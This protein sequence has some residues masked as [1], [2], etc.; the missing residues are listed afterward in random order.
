MP[1]FSKWT[2]VFFVWLIL[3]GQSRMDSGDGSGEWDDSDIA[4]EKLKKQKLVRTVLS[5]ITKNASDILY[6]ARDD[7]EV[8]ANF[9]REMKKKM[10]KRGGKSCCVSSVVNIV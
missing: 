6:I 10:R 3:I 9:E 5:Y 7:H 4:D 8:I 1:S 2:L